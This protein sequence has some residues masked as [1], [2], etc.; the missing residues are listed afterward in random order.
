MDK[1]ELLLKEITEA[2]GVSGYESEIRKIM[3]REMKDNVDR[4]EYDKLG[5]VLG[6]K[7]GTADSPRIMVI[8]HMDEIGF[9]VKEIT[10]EGYIKFLPLGGWW[11]HVALGQRMRVITSKGT[12][13]GVVGSKPPHLLPMEERKKVLEIKDMF[14]DIGVQEK[15]DVKKRLGVKP[16]DPIIPDSQFTIM[17]NKKMYLSKAFDN[18]ASCAIVLELLERLSRVKHPNT[19]LGGGTVQ[20]EVGLRGAHTIAHLGDPDV[21]FTVDIGVGRDVPPDGFAVPERLGSGVSI[22]I[23]DAG[24][25]PNIKLRDLFVKTAERKKIPYHLSYMERGTGDGS[26]VQLSRLGVPSIYVGPPVRYIHSHNGVMNRTDYDNTIK[27]FIE[28]IQKLDRKTVKS[29]TEG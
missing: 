16:G 28:V 24:M 23:Y 10:R 29:L 6:H 26:R 11:G 13:I 7:K 17:G 25:I 9:M 4:I 1:T 15:Y 8:G 3:V 14:I 5:S 2:N 27:L 12:L 19:V 22:V 21:C 20:E 18:R